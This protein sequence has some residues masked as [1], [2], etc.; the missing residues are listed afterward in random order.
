[1]GRGV[2]AACTAADDGD[3][4]VGKLVGQLAGS[5]DAVMRGHARADHGDGVLV[6]HTQ[7]PFDVEHNRRVVN[8]AQQ[9]RV[10]GVG[11]RHDAAAGIRDALELGSQVDG[12]LPG[13]DGLGGVFTDAA[14]LE[15]L[16]PGR[17]QDGRRVAEV[18]EQLP[19]ADGA[20]VL[21]QIQR[22]QGFVGLH[23]RG[24]AGSQRRGKRKRGARRRP[25]SEIRRKAEA[26]RP[27]CGLRKGF[28]SA[29]S[30]RAFGL[31][32]S[33]SIEPNLRTRTGNCFPGRLCHPPQSCPG[34]T[35]EGPRRYPGVAPMLIA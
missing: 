3:A 26:R 20:D 15:Q 7:G 34:N 13:G 18:L 31:P 4:E 16:G 12:L 27:K 24:I 2:D 14:D 11:L 10:F 32:A 17:P 22:H 33:D 9:L 5:F 21:N 35:P 19:H 29:V 23:A 30:C 25:K 1:M 6:L 8:L 28:V